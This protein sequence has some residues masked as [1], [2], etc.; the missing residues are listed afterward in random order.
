MNKENCWSLKYSSFY[1]QEKFA[2]VLFKE[3]FP[4]YEFNALV[5]SSSALNWNWPSSR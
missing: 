2:F 4:V 3:T 5:I 1:K